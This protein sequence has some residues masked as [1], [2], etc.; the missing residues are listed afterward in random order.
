MLPPFSS[1]AQYVSSVAAEDMRRRAEA[2]RRHVAEQLGAAVAARAA[3]VA[4]IEAAAAAEERGVPARVSRLYSDSIAAADARSR[5]PGADITSASV[6]AGL[7]PAPPAPLGSSARGGH[8]PLAFDAG[9]EA[10]GDAMVAMGLP[11]LGAH[12]TRPPAA[13]VAHALEHKRLL[14]E[15]TA[16]ALPPPDHPIRQQ[17][18]AAQVRE[19]AAAGQVREAAAAGPRLA[20][21]R[22]YPPPPPRLHPCRRTPS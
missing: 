22:R 18:A 16:A 10:V 19:A 4:R 2:D 7:V 13:A 17:A 6:A 5:R 1:S 12:A 20:G 8:A 3:S 11:R 21:L 14:Q 9:D 15:A